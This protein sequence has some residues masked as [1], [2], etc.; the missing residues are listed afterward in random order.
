MLSVPNSTRALLEEIV[1]TF[2]SPI[3]YAFAYGSGVFEQEGMSL[4]KNKKPMLDFIFAVS[5]PEHWHS[6]N[7]T[8]NPSH[9][10]LHAR[11][12]GSDFVGRVQNW[13]PA[14]VWFN[15]FVPVSGVV[16]AAPGIT[17]IYVLTDITFRTLNMALFPSTT[18]V[19]TCS[20]GTHSTLPVECTSP[21]ELP[22]TTLVCDS[23]NK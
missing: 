19:P 14:A 23:R 16:G 22:K 21:Y 9:Y 8:Q 4:D 15:P 2:N 5:H 3:R 17:I 7:L 6:I 12:L 10:A 20:H 11:L 18:Y 1:A 13:G